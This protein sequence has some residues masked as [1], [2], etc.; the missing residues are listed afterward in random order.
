MNI[1]SMIVYLKD[2]K[3]VSDVA[4]EMAKID[5]CEIVATQDEKIVATM[6]TDDQNTQIANFR[7]IERIYGVRDVAMVYDYE[8]LDDD[9]KIANENNIEK[10]VRKI[11][12]SDVSEIKYGGNVNLK[13][14][15]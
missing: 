9:I 8:E 13:L 7:F 12:D 2:A 6:Q 3:F 5:G 4:D 15:V 14:N 11:D 1:S 10:I